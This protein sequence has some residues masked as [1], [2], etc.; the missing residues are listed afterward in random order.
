[1]ALRAACMRAARSECVSNEKRSFVLIYSF[2]EEEERG[3][4]CGRRNTEDKG[5]KSTCLAVFFM[6]SVVIEKS[7]ENKL[8]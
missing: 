2:R 4:K 3:G 1:M 6:W 5:R 8:C 7:R